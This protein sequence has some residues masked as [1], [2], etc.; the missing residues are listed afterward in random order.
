M[1]FRS[2]TEINNY[3]NFLLELDKK[4]TKD[5][6]HH[7]DNVNRF[8]E[9]L[10]NISKSFINTSFTSV[11]DKNSLKYDPNLYD[12]NIND[13]KLDNIEKKKLNISI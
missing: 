2:H 6:I 13:T 7:F 10:K 4:Q 8:D 9:T 5:K 11:T 12:S 1:K 3:N